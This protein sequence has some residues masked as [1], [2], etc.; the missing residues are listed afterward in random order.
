[1]SVAYIAGPITGRKDY[2][3]KFHRAERY[4]KGCGYDVVLNPAAVLPEGL[5]NRT[6]MQICVRMIDTCDAVFF[7]PDWQESAGAQLEHAYCEYTGAKI[8]Y[9]KEDVIK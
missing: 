1:M 8:E 3:T 6:A 7:L 2:K 5:D 9:L 4:L